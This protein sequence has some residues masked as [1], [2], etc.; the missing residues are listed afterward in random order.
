MT[1]SFM[2]FFV[3]EAVQISSSSWLP[4]CSLSVCL[5]HEKI[6]IFLACDA[7]HSASLSLESACLLTLSRLIQPLCPHLLLHSLWW[8]KAK[9]LKH[10]QLLVIFLLCLPPESDSLP[11]L[12]SF[13][14]WFLS[15][16]WIKKGKYYETMDTT[17]VYI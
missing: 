11:C 14:S 8:K 17:Y 15:H 5:R 1:T 16:M 7:C 2:V 9:K 13:V 6:A 12:V 4:I 10:G 3:L